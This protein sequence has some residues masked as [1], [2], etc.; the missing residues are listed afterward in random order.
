MLKSPGNC[1]RRLGC[2]FS[3]HHFQ[4]FK[5]Y[6]SVPLLIMQQNPCSYFFLLFLLNYLFLGA[7]HSSPPQEWVQTA[8]R[9]MWLGAPGAPVISV[10]S[11]CSPTSSP[12]FQ[13]QRILCLVNLSK[14]VKAF[15]FPVVRHG[16]LPRISREF[17]LPNSFPSQK[18]MLSSHLQQFIV[19]GW[20]REKGDVDC[21]Q[22][23]RF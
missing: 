10:L 2:S 4:P 6:S 23:C 21:F 1:E 17:Y 7:F 18:I 15:C 5:S 19:G 8:F 16:P 13:S 3:L 9:T 11:S 22:H 20:E 12:A 14:A